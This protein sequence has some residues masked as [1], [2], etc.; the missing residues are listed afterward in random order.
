MIPNTRPQNFSS[1]YGKTVP[2]PQGTLDP[3]GNLNRDPANPVPAANAPLID[4]SFKADWSSGGSVMPQYVGQL[5][6]K[7]VTAQGAFIA[8]KTKIFREQNPDVPRKSL[9]RLVEEEADEEWSKLGETEKKLFEDLSKEDQS[10]YVTQMEKFKSANPG[11]VKWHEL[12][13]SV[14]KKDGHHRKQSVAA[15]PKPRPP[16]TPWMAYVQ[17]QTQKRLEADPSLKPGLQLT[18]QIMKEVSPKWRNLS[19]RSRLKWIRIAKADRQRF[20]EELVKNPEYAQ[21]LKAKEAKKAE[22]KAAKAEAKKRAKGESNQGDGVPAANPTPRQASQKRRSG[23]A[24]AA[25]AIRGVTRAARRTRQNSGPEDEPPLEAQARQ[26]GKPDRRSGNPKE[27]T[28]KDAAAGPKGPVRKR[29]S[30][31]TENLQENQEDGGRG[32]VAPQ[33]AKGHAQENI[34]PQGGAA[35]T[36]RTGANLQ[37]AGKASVRGLSANPDLPRRGAQQKRA[38]RLDCM[39]LAPVAAAEPVHAEPPTNTDPTSAQKKAGTAVVENPA[40]ALH[41]DDSSSEEDDSEGEE[42]GGVNKENEEDAIEDE[43]S[44]SEDDGE[45]EV[46]NEARSMVGKLFGGGSK[47]TPLKPLQREGSAKPAG[48]LVGCSVV[49]SFW[50]DGEAVPFNGTVVSYKPIQKWYRVVYSDGDA[51]D[52]TDEELQ[53]FLVASTPS[54]QRK[55]KAT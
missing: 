3:L 2:R 32:E 28:P 12:H 31:A 5:P 55:R 15:M 54:P 13:E 10:R 51:E 22:R 39:Q 4:W 6:K 24:I 48:A 45:P 26:V 19:D 46:I 33:G 9:K 14:E 8:Y 7:P 25:N 38:K 49:R 36:T 43:E 11:W 42:Y 47:R 41:S 44:D 34:I 53:L 27:A 52:L 29:K 23:P 16:L 18:V 21:K 37:A 30:S 40:P 17:N 35:R 50:V 1:F 20:E